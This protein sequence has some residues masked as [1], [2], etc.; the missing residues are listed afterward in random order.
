[1]ALLYH[2]IFRSEIFRLVIKERKIRKLTKD[3][4][5]DRIKHYEQLVFYSVYSDY[6]TKD[7]Y[8]KFIRKEF[9]TQKNINLQ[10]FN[11]LFIIDSIKYQDLTDIHMIISN[12]S[13]QF[14]RKDKSPAPFICFRNLDN[15]VLNKIKQDMI[16]NN[17]TFADG[18]MFN[19]DKFRMDKLINHS[20]D[21]ISVKF[22]H[23]EHISQLI[24][25]KTFQQIYQFFINSSAE[26]ETKH[27]HIKIQIQELNQINQIIN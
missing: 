11:R 18:T 7:S 17:F 1:M 23:E 26:V 3:V 22:I 10:N 8:E 5:D 15:A 14:Y 24:E 4:L 20:I 21:N 9:F 25:K 19:G 27:K 16:D 13:K 12:I 6:L 2:S